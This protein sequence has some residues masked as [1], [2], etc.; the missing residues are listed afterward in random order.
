[1][2][3][4]HTKIFI[5][6]PR[7]LF[8]LEQQRNE[9]IPNIVTLLQKQV[10]GWI[11]RRNFKK[12]KAAITIMRAYKTYK[13]RSYVQE[14]ANRFRNAKQMRDYGKS[15]QW[16]QPPLA[17][18]KAEAKLHRVFDFW[19][20]CMI[21]R[22]YPRNEWPQ[23]RLQIIAATALAGRRPYWGQTRRW[24]GDYLANSLDNSGYEAYNTSVR[25]IRNNLAGVAGAESFRQVLF[26]AFA[27]K[28][29][30]HNKQSDRAFIVTDSTIYKLEGVKKKFKDM[31]RHIGIREVGTK[32]YHS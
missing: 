7:T 31:K 29:N 21:L 24:V 2:K 15:I 17:G 8:A 10:R 3:Y 14:L 30:H 25:N 20:A 28:F 18:R 1:V 9:M 12:M 32:Y 26:S 19:R 13:L 6:S 5:R 22:K 4:G 16:P 11:V 27:K 23:L